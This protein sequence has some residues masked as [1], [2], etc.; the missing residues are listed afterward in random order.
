M[1]TLGGL[2]V[3]VGHLTFITYLTLE[4]LGK[5]LGSRVGAFDL[6][7][8]MNGTKSHHHISRLCSL[9]LNKGHLQVTRTC[10]Q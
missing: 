1:R 2:Q 8:S 3:Y 5:S 9:T 7:G 4:N 10:F 6:F